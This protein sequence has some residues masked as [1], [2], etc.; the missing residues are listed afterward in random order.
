TALPYL[1]NSCISQGDTRQLVARIYAGTGSNQ[2]NISC[3]AGHLQYTSQGATSLTSV[4]P[5]VSI[6]PNGVATANQPGSVLISANIANAAS[7]AGFFSTRPPA[8]ITLPAPGTTS[9]P[10]VVN[11]NNP[12]PLLATAVDTKNV[13]LT[14]LTLEYVSTSPTTIPAGSTVTPTLAGAAPLSSTLQTPNCNSE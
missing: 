2:T 10:V 7:S 5:V 13:T 9:N 3:Q 14:G 12:Q 1:A 6:D 11:E 8:S 4:S